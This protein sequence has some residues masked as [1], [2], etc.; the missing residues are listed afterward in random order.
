MLLN[1]H[2][3]SQLWKI[4]KWNKVCS[5][6]QTG[7]M[8][9]SRTR[10]TLRHQTINVVWSYYELATFRK[11]EQTRGWHPQS[12]QE[13]RRRRMKSN[14]ES[15]PDDASTFEEHP[16]QKKKKKIHLFLTRC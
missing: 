13:V 14:P 6:R 3:L 1:S 11:T 2:F 8:K 10:S 15:V 5:E 7:W 16:E 4:W 12:F 9:N